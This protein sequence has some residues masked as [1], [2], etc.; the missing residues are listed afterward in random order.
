MMR[1]RRG[2]VLLGLILL[3]LFFTAAHPLEILK[4]QLV[5]AIDSLQKTSREDD[6]SLSHLQAES[7]VLIDETTGEVL[8]SKNATQRLYPA[9]TTKIMTAW[10]AIEQGKLTDRITVG[11]EVNERTA[12]ESSAW[13]VEGQ[14]L[15]LKDLLTALML[16]SGNDAARTI[17]RY[18]AEKENSG[19]AMS[20]DDS[21][22][23]AKLM[24]QKA[25][26]L[27]AKQT[28]FVNPH[29]LHD[30]KHYTTASD[31]ALIANAAMEN[32]TFRQIVNKQITRPAWPR[33]ES[34]E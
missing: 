22:R 8:Y 18:I 17:A 9:S 32:E 12:D 29:G 31:M 13:L 10:I 34:N 15:T 33:T 28:H 3:T 21:V 24:N 30:P 11:D 16:P 27:G 6:T 20:M 26:V 19:E 7:A 14:T 4:P 1:I 23:F 5:W 2:T 25:K